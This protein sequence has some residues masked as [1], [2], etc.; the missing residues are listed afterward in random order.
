M[1]HQQVKSHSVEMIQSDVLH[2]RKAKLLLR[3][4]WGRQEVISSSMR[5]SEGPE[6]V[7]SRPSQRT[8]SKQHQIPLGGLI[9]F[10]ERPECP[11]M[12]ELVHSHPAY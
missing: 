7:T 11:E 1:C 2:F 4:V 12:P 10:L 9:D 6:V 8:H 3:I 5:T